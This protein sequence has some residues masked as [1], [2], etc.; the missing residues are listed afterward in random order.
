VTDL[1][2]ERQCHFSVSLPES[3]VARLDAIREERASSRA[4]VVRE[5]VRFWLRH[6]QQPARVAS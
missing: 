2:G 1:K 5:A 3:D 6:Q 4:D